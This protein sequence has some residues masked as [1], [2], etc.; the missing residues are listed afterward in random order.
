MHRSV[1]L[2]RALSAV[3]GLLL[4]VGP[5]KASAQTV[6]ACK[7]NTSGLL[8]FYATSPSVGCGPGRTLETF[9]LT[10]G[11]LGASAFSCN[12]KGGN[13]LTSGGSLAGNA[14]NFLVGQS[15]GSGI[16]YNNG[17]TFLLQPGTYLVQLSVSDVFLQYQPQ[18][19]GQTA[20]LVVNLT[21]NGST[22]FLDITGSIN[23]IPNSIS[24][25]VAVNGN[26]LLKVLNANTVI[27]FNVSF[28]TDH[29]ITGGCQIVFTQLQ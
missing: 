5:Q 3:I 22:G 8:F 28:N 17:T 14:G 18:P 9:N 7:D 11:A 24:A 15:F 27:G 10:P 1:V 19:I 4:L 20:D 16:G 2:A 6:F 21:V 12:I 29:A 25:F 23:T 26:Q 13:S